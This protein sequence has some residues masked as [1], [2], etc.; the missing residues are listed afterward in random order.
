MLRGRVV[1]HYIGRI[2][3]SIVQV[4]IP[5]VSMGRCSVSSVL[6]RL[7]RVACDRF[8][9][10]NS[11]MRSFS[12]GYWMVGYL[13]VISSRVVV[14]ITCRFIND[15]AAK[16]VVDQRGLEFVSINDFM[17]YGFMMYDCLVMDRDGMVDRNSMCDCVMS[18]CSFGVSMSFGF[19]FVMLCLRGGL[20][21]VDLMM[22]GELTS[23]SIIIVHLEDKAAILDVNLTRHEEG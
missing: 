3:V 20:L 21:V 8:V 10:M 2:R 22:K 15:I 17:H 18:G 9:S 1:V 5:E 13:N 7:F 12:V 16:R 11:V 14:R 6:M 23:M 4:S 19:C